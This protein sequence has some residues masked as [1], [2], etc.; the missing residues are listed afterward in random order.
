LRQA[1]FMG[2]QWVLIGC[3]GQSLVIM[4]DD[5]YKKQV[6]KYLTAKEKLITV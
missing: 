3:R 6:V 2:G 4:Y 1:F 5:D